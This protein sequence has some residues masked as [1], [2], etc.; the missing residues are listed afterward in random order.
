MGVSVVV[1]GQFGSEGK[2]KVSRIFAKKHEATAVVRVG[3]INSGHTV[4]DQAGNPVIFRIL[5]TAA[6]DKNAYCVLPAGSYLD[7]DL[8]F[9]EIKQ[10]GID[11][12]K[13]K[14]HEN[15]AVITQE[16]VAMERTGNLSAMIGSTGSGT[17]A[18]VS[19]RAAR[20]P[21]FLRAKEVEVL[22]PF[23]CDT[24]EFL[25]EEL[26]RGHEILVEGTQGFGLSNLHS[27][28]YPYATSRDTTAAGF[29]SEAGLSPF[30]VTNIIMVIRTFP[31][32]V[33]G[34]SGP[35]PNETTWEAVTKY[36]NSSVPI[37]EYTSV[38][39]KLRR[40]GE[41]D[42]DIVRKAITVNRP[43]QIV[44][45]HMDY[46]YDAVDRSGSTRQRFVEEVQRKIGTDI[47]YI[48]V[49]RQTILPV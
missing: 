36:A 16:Q 39:K 17:G 26:S 12:A 46:I 34:K 30:D 22:R 41:F 27:Q 42:A 23:L 4:I 29:I 13:V 2:G 37:K 48:G 25:R 31:I 28:Y 20:D 11:P 10:S 15:A 40:V 44:L 5:P 18:S 32:R 43:N 6:I 1:G 14:I 45:N 35:L 38:T 21:A 7:I 19:M 9:Q 3:G 24:S 49:D 33:S 47:H 8:L